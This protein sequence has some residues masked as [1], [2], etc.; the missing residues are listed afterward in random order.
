MMGPGWVNIDDQGAT[1]ALLE[2]LAVRVPPAVIDTLWLFPTRRASGVESTV[3]IISA[4]DPDDSERRKVGA[5]RW[6][7]M[8]DRRGAASITEDMHEYATAPADALQRVVDGVMRR[9]GDDA[10]EPPRL[11]ELGG[12]TR[13]WDELLRD[14]GA[15][16]PRP[17]ETTPDADPAG[18]DTAIASGED[19][20]SVGG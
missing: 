9:L 5:A 19:A 8:R 13:A 15:P 3:A 11:V 14:L 6:L 10:R 2:R 4:F 1:W 17:A 12:E 7:V 18:E 16:A 20:A